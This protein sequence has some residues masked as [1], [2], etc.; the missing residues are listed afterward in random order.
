MKPVDAVG[1]WEIELVMVG[2]VSD[3]CRDARNH[4]RRENE[5]G[6]ESNQ[7]ASAQ[8]SCLPEMN[9]GLRL[10]RSAGESLP[11]YSPFLPPIV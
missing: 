7:T 5:K 1:G 9:R 11:N 4:G 3:G 10:L 8:G 2:V 6:E